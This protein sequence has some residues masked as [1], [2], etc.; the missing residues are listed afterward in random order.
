MKLTG[1]TRSKDMVNGKELRRQSVVIS[2]LIILIISLIIETFIFNYNHWKSI[3]NG[4]GEEL[5]LPNSS[6]SGSEA[7][8]ALDNLNVRVSTIGVIFSSKQENNVIVKAN[9]S[10]TDQGNSSYYALP[11]TEMTLENNR[12]QTYAISPYGGIIHGIKADFDANIGNVSINA[13]VLNRCVPF[14]FS[15]T[16][17]FCTFALLLLAYSTK[18]KSD[19]FATN[20]MKSTKASVVLLLAVLIV[21]TSSLA[22]GSD[23]TDKPWYDT[24]AHNEYT[25]LARSFRNGHLYLEEE[26][27][28]W[29][30]DLENPYDPGARE[31]MVEKSGQPYKNDAAYYDGK[32]YVYFGVVPV[33]IAYLPY[34]LFTGL[35]LE[36]SAAVAFALANFAFGLWLLLREIIRT[37]YQNVTFGRFAITYIAI[38]AVSG[39]VASFGRPSFY[40]VPVSFALAFAMYGL[41]FWMRGFRLGS[42]IQ[43]VAGSLCASLVAGCRPQL[44]IFV[45]PYFL[46]AKRI[47][48]SD[49]KIR[50]KTIRLMQL[51]LPC[52][53]VAI[54]LMAYNWARF[55]SV[56]DFGANYNLAGNDMTLRGHDLVRL[57]EGVF[58]YLFQPPSLGTK[59]P[60]LLPSY[61]SFTFGGLTVSEPLLGGLFA[62]F[63]VLLVSP[64]LWAVP[65][66]RASDRKLSIALF[67]AAVGVCA[68][69]VEGAGLLPRYGQDFGILFGFSLMIVVFSLD[70][71]SNL[72]ELANFI[73]KIATVASVISLVLIRLAM[74]SPL[75][76]ATGTSGV[77]ATM[78]EYWRTFFQ[79]WA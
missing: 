33:L 71:S 10:I 68:F 77:T 62:L 66:L 4:A 7:H 24:F 55:G 2:I 27:P 1:T 57:F 25:E 37:R 67:V 69:D 5:I 17:F 26:P 75:A 64:A 51:S 31:Q 30:H 44:L 12:S 8:Y 74:L 61:P 29:L 15:V 18:R 42:S 34:L 20:A 3:L 78:W 48:C 56:F 11:E 14:V 52:V 21:S 36:N 16:R 39:I 63:P 9:Y 58:Y 50:Y 47:I 59:F 32:Y 45:L 73:L 28:S 38:L 70:N 72:S 53:L 43:I 54:S 60:F 35:P 41:F 6:L 23:D 49:K 40:N 13:I 46:Y 19:L 22:F 79:F 76:G 65:S